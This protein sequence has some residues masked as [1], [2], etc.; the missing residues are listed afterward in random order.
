MAVPTSAPRMITSAGVSPTRFCATNEV[1]SSVVALLLCTS[2]VTP[3]PAM[4]AI[5][6][7]STLRLSTRRKSAP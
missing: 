7:F 1:T 6:F 3:M 2:A 5:G 4:N